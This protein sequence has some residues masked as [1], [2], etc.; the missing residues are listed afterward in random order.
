MLLF[1]GNLET[2]DVQEGEKE[3]WVL[4]NAIT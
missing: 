3:E 4:I 1:E 2:V